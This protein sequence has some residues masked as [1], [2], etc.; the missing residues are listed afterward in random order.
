MVEF[1]GGTGWEA[2]DRQRKWT[3]MARA[4]P[5]FISLGRGF[6]MSDKIPS[7]VI[8]V[9]GEVFNEHYTHAEIDRLFAYADAPDINPGGNK[10]QKTVEW[11]HSINQN[12]PQP[13]KILGL[14]LEKIMDDPTEEPNT[15]W[16]GGSALSVFLKERQGKIYAILGRSN[17]S[18]SRGGIISAA[19][20]SSTR[21]LQDLVNSGGLQNI[22]VEIDR[23]LKQVQDD[24]NDAA[25]YAGNVLESAFKTYL[26][27]QMIDFS[28]IETLS[29]LW[30]LVRNDLGLNP[31]D[32][33][34]NDLKKIA[35]G[36]NSIVDG[37]TFIRNAKSG[38][39]GRSEEQAALTA[40]GPRHAR[41][42]IHAAHT[43]A[44]YVLECLADSRKGK[45]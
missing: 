43:L 40:I 4:I 27:R 5:A 7:P 30:P 20:A 45:S 39:H 41:L 14:L 29:G 8:G 16:G 12:S 28:E 35:S 17:L 32:M 44:I 24:P 21:S 23:A 19:G 25:L 15:A 22:R 13:L 10:V 42:V 38:A 26:S 6:K 37:T 36:L 11:L 1:S 33:T 31:K 34:S 2:D 18:Y 9:L 3:G